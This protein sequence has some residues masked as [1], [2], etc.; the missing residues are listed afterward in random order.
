M[1]KPHK[2]YQDYLHIPVVNTFDLDPTNTEEVQS[3]IKT[4]KG[5]VCCIFASLF[6]R[7]KREHLSN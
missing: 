3:Y 6:F 1:V 2:K 4:L 7:S 5:C